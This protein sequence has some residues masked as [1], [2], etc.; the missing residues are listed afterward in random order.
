MK[1]WEAIKRV[2]ETFRSTSKSGSGKGDGYKEITKNKREW[3]LKYFFEEGFTRV[4]SSTSKGAM[5]VVYRGI[6]VEHFT[7][8]AEQSSYEW[9][10]MSDGKL[11]TKPDGEDYIFY[12]DMIH[13]KVRLNKVDYYNLLEEMLDVYMGLAFVSSSEKNMLNGWKEKAK[14]A[15]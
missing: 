6:L 7:A 11:F 1:I 9:D 12:Y 10:L 15:L 13:E 3:L 4:W 2:F 5:R 14:A 8:L